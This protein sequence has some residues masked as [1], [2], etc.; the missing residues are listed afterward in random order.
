MS[1]GMSNGNDMVMPVTPMGYGGGNGRV[2]LQV[3]A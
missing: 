2:D 3:P 1:Y